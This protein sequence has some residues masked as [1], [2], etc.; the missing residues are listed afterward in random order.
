MRAVAPPDLVESIFV[1]SEEKS[2]VKPVI[3]SGFVE[4]VNN[5]NSSSRLAVPRKARV[6]SFT[7][8]SESRMLPL[9]SS[10][11]PKEQGGSP[12]EKERS[13]G[14]SGHRVQ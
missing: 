5:R 14:A 2:F 4:T 12:L 8:W 13:V 6:T 9:I 7:V 3:G 1:S 10:T 11:N